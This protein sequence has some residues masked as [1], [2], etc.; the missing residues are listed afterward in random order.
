MMNSHL[1]LALAQAHQ[2]DLQR[3]A[4]TAGTGRRAERKALRRR[5]GHARLLAALT[6]GAQVRRV[7]QPA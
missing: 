4:S 1:S 3:A 7:R 2:T 5:S 6:R